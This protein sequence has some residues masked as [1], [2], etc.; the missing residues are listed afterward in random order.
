MKIRRIRSEKKATG[1]HQKKH[2]TNT[3]YTITPTKK[4]KPSRRR[5]PQI[6]HTQSKTDR[7]SDDDDEDMN[8]K[9]TIDQIKR[10]KAHSVN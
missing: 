2:R 4:K 9:L 5:C 6:K 1:F 3:R 10:I 7:T 8:L